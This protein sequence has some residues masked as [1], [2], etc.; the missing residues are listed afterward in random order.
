MS[1]YFSDKELGE[2]ERN[3]EKITRDVWDGIFS[4][5]QD[6]VTNN[7]LSGKFPK[8][9]QDGQGI[10]GC[11]RLQLERRVKSEIP[12][13]DIPIEASTEEVIDFSF[14][15]DEDT[16]KVILPEKYAILDF[17]E[18]LYKNIQDPKPIGRYHEYYNHYHY[19]F[20]DEGDSVNQFVGDINTI[21][22]RNGIVFYLSGNGKIKRIIHKP[23]KKKI[24]QTKHWLKKYPNALGH[25]S[26]AIEKYKNGK[27][28]RNLLDDLRV[29][30]VHQPR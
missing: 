30:L 13:L 19:K 12:K 14:D 18:F 27:Y 24:K 20:S 7:K 2:V 11:D 16:T 17:I 22:K 26:Q 4:I 23:M 29:S 6:L 5:Y 9:C 8:E 25:Y 15:S 1:K 10:C 21:F 28:P 3:S